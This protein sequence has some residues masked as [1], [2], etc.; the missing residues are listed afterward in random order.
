M[1]TYCFRLIIADTA[2]MAQKVNLDTDLIYQ[3][4]MTEDIL[5][6]IHKIVVGVCFTYNPTGKHHGLFI[7]AD[8]IKTINSEKLDHE[9]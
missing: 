6:D 5:C 2:R 3:S 7:K 4:H 9:S 8:L 1:V